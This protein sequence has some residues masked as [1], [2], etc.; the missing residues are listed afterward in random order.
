MQQAQFIKNSFAVYTPA[1]ALSRRSLATACVS[2]LFAVLDRL[3][4]YSAPVI[5]SAECLGRDPG[6]LSGK[7]SLQG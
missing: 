3:H 1:A 4:L 6:A 2:G 7:N 5:I